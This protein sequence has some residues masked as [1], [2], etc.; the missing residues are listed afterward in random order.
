MQLARSRRSA[1]FGRR[2][3]SGFGTRIIVNS[4][5]RQ[6]GGKTAFEWR[7]EGLSCVLR[8]PRN[9]AGDAQAASGVA[10]LP[11][12]KPTTSMPGR[13]IMIVE[14]EALVA[15]VLEDQLADLG[16]SIVAT[17][18]TVTEA[19]AAIDEKAPDSAIL[20]VNLGGQFVYPVADR[21]LERGIPFVFVTGY[22][23]ESVDR[24]Y[25]SVRVLEKP[26]ERHALELIFAKA[27]EDVGL[28]THGA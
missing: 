6:L 10:M 16:L 15:M 17:C 21:L 24:R 14:D 12:K 4:I 18:P 20:D 23:P 22:G 9:E 7:P 1:A 19:I 11:S 25:A 26:V 27:P 8:V 2:A 13:R 28:V 3:R 5:E